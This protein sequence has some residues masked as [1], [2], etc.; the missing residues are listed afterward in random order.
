MNATLLMTSR[1]LAFTLFLQGIEYFLLTRKE[2]FTKVWSF[3]NLKDE[4]KIRFLFSDLSFK[5]IVI[6]QIL[7][8]L[9]AFIFPQTYL[10]VLL[11]LTTLL[12]TIRFRGSFNGGSDMMSFV[13]LTGVLISFFAKNPEM[14]KFGLIY[15]GIHGIYSYFKAGL[16]KI[17][18]A[19]WRNGS[20]LKGFSQVS[21]YPVVRS[22]KISPLLSLVLGWITILFE[23]GT[24]SVLVVPDMVGVY[25]IL[26][27]IFHLMVFATF[28]LNR[29]FW[30]WMSAW[31]GIFF[32]ADH[33]LR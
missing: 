25:F 31:P 12:I 27:I 10:F 28:G 5:I 13:V 32:T 11:F 9:T 29:F 15:I 26:A 18:H 8:S 30:I 3:E 23:L 16:A 1:L 6:L 4:L 14:G 2:L 24:V 7:T 17:R 33:L 21:L 22:L 20:A 19:D